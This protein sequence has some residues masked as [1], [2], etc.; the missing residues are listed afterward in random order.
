MTT[1]RKEAWKEVIAIIDG[2][3]NY[4]IGSVEYD[5]HANEIYLNCV[6]EN[7]EPIHR[8]KVESLN[9]RAKKLI[10]E[11]SHD[12]GARVCLDEDI[13]SEGNP[14]RAIVED[15][16]GIS[17]ACSVI[18]C[19][20]D[21]DKVSGYAHASGKTPYDV[22]SDTLLTVGDLCYQISV[23]RVDYYLGGFVDKNVGIEFKDNHITLKCKGKELDAIVL[24]TV[25]AVSPEDAGITQDEADDLFGL[26][27]NSSPILS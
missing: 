10:G 23:D 21:T 2:T 6:N 3:R 9:D 15:N 14:V 25:D 26:M 8:F 5:H 18:Y 22:Y 7:K 27:A 13:D 19:D 17:I 1:T 24:G 20:S 11:I 12:W 16:S 4:R